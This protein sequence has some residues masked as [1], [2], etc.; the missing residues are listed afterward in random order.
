MAQTLQPLPPLQTLRAF[1]SVARARGFSRAAAQLG[2]TQTAVSHQ[3][4]QL[5]EWVG[6]QLFTRDR[7]Q[8]E[9]TVLGAKLLP[10]VDRALGDLQHALWSL[11]ASTANRRLRI[12][13]TPE[14][15][16][17]WLTPRLDG[18]CDAHPDIDVNVVIAYRRARFIEDD[19]DLAIWLGCGA[20]DQTAERLL[21]D[22]EFAVCAPNVAKKLPKRHALRAAPLLRYD[23][24]RHTVLDWRRWC[25][26]LFGDDGERRDGAE[27]ALAGLDL[28]AGPCYPT[29]ADMLK[30]CRRGAGF[31][32]VR[33]SLVSKDLA[34][35][36]LVRCF[37]ES[38]PSDLHYH[39]IYPPAATKRPEVRVFR[40]WIMAVSAQP[41]SG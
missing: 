9:L 15:A 32:L 36:R 7:R 12:S 28:D 19:I 18:F 35:G 27:G 25:S 17:Q 3:I 30:A 24:A 41:Q 39:L 5:E 1:V 26:Q 23:G 31:A 2:L 21:M 33:T 40:D 16:A 8:V 37:V 10:T 14:F 13:T 34:S 22:E 11:R 29:F 38:L 6:G 20:A 4:A